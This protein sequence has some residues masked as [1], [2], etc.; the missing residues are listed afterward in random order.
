MVQGSMEE[1][2]TLYYLGRRRQ[3][4]I[5]LNRVI[6]TGEKL[7]LLQSMYVCMSSIDPMWPRQTL[8]HKC[9]SLHHYGP[10]GPCIHLRKELESN[11]GL[12]ERQPSLLPTEMTLQNVLCLKFRRFQKLIYQ[13]HRKR[14]ARGSP[15]PP[16]QVRGGPEYIE[17]STFT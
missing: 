2:C 14:G 12:D 16:F 9:T 15:T 3:G 8:C 5:T 7:E 13:G 4:T 1:F 6:I 17:P 10:I 11:Q